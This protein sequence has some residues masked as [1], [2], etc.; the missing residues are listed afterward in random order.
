MSIVENLVKATL[1]GSLEVQSTVG[2]GTTVAITL[3]LTAPQPTPEEDA[4]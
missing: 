4:G 2:Q 3:P 1:G